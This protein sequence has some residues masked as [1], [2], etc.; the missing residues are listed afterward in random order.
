M[1]APGG[2][3]ALLL[4]NCLRKCYCSRGGIFL[5]VFPRS[6]N[7]NAET[8]ICIDHKAFMLV[9]CDNSVY[10][11]GGNYGKKLTGGIGYV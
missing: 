8:G 1:D 10:N 6:L 7:C 9:V 2:F 11:K 4:I 3:R 5:P